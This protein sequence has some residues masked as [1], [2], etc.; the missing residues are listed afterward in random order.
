[1]HNFI[2][3]IES[4]SHVCKLHRERHINA[5]QKIEHIC[6]ISQICAPG[7]LLFFAWPFFTQGFNL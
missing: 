5:H 6:Q 4:S 3:Y 1:M 7:V 2:F